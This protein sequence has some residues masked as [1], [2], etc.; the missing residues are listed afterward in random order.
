MFHLIVVK[1][2]VLKGKKWISEINKLNISFIV[3]VNIVFWTEDIVSLIVPRKWLG[4]D[5]FLFPFETLI[6]R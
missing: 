2:H 4:S 6:R 3:N 1:R 5:F